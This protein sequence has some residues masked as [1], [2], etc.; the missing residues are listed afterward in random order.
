MQIQIVNPHNLGTPYIQN[1][2]SLPGSFIPLFSIWPGFGNRYS[3][4]SHHEASLMD[5][6]LLVVAICDS[7]NG[8]VVID[9]G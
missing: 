6:L 7:L 9:D 1:P 2:G 4:N 5:A 3:Q 8:E